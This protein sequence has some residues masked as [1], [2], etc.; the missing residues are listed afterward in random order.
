MKYAIDFV[1][2]DPVWTNW[3]RD[4]VIAFKINIISIQSITIKSNLI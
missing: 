3:I 2:D 1:N 4:L